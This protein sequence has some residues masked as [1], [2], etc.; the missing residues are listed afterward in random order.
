MYSIE[1]QKRGLPHSR[2]LILRKIKIKA[3]DIDKI[4]WVPLPDS[5]DDKDLL[6]IIPSQMI[7]EPCGSLNIRCRCC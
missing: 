5:K 1:Y 6:D 3:L 2:T 7:H 4:I